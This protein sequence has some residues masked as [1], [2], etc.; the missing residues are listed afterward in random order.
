[1]KVLGTGRRLAAAPIVFRTA[2]VIFFSSKF[3]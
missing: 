2:A 1:M 3:D